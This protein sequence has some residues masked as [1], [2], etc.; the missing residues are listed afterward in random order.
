MT[1]QTP[2]DLCAEAAAADVPGMERQASLSSGKGGARHSEASKGAWPPVAQPARSA[3]CLLLPP[4]CL[5]VVGQPLLTLASG[6]SGL[7]LPTVMACGSSQAPGTSEEAFPA[8]PGDACDGTFDK[9]DTLLSS[10][11]PPPPKK[12]R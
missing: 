6:P 10:Y 5:A 9:A 7:A 4:S 1:E 2:A 12:K 8:L 3:S 11:S